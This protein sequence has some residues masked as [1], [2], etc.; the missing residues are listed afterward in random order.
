MSGGKICQFV[1]VG[2][3]GEKA[4]YILSALSLDHPENGPG[5]N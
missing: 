4:S 3:Q 1:G 2:G 5:E